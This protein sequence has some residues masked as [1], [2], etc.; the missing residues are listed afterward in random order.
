[1]SKPRPTT[2]SK[3]LELL[4]T[5]YA[6]SAEKAATYLG[7]H[8]KTVGNWFCML[9]NEGVV[10]KLYKDR[11]TRQYFYAIQRGPNGLSKVGNSASRGAQ[12]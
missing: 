4:S 8:P 5:H 3:I 11:K 10:D 7:M 1:M 9:A 6:L 12:V 2:R